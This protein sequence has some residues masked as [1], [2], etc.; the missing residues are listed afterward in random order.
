[1][2]NI[3]KIIVGNI[4]KIIVGNKQWTRCLI[5]IRAYNVASMLHSSLVHLWLSWHM[6]FHFL[7]RPFMIRNHESPTPTDTSSELFWRIPTPSKP[8]LKKC[9]YQSVDDAEPFQFSLFW[10]QKSYMCTKYIQVQCKG[11]GGCQISGNNLVSTVFPCGKICKTVENNFG[12]SSSTE[13]VLSPPPRCWV[14]DYTK[15]LSLFQR[16]YFILGNAFPGSFARLLQKK[17]ETL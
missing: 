16:Y 9:T 8:F 5:L 13:C 15:K 11:V 4:V 1:M 6:S 12:E 14:Q 2:G 7:G 10:N 3:V 17:T